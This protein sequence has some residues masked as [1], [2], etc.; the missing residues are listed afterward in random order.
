MA[1]FRSA[2]H[3]LSDGVKLLVSKIILGEGAYE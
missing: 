1:A 2:C 3:L